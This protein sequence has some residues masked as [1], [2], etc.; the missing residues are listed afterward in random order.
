MHI[1]KDSESRIVQSTPPDWVEEIAVDF[2]AKP[3]SGKAN[4]GIWC[5]LVN[6]Q[7]NLEDKVFYRRDV[8]KILTVQGAQEG[9]RIQIRFDPQYQE[10]LVHRLAIVR[11]GRV[12]DYLPDQEVQVLQREEI[13]EWHVFSGD[14][15]AVMLLKDIQVGDL[16][17]C[18]H[19]IK[20]KELPHKM[21]D[22]GKFLLRG[23]LSIQTVS[24][25]LLYSSQ[26]QVY[27]VPHNTQMQPKMAFD[28]NGLVEC[29]WTMSNP[30]PI[31]PEDG[32][33]S[34]YD[35]CEWV[36]YGAYS[37]WSEFAAWCC[38][39]FRMPD[40]L[41][42]QALEVVGRLQQAGGTPEE[43]I[44]AALKFVQ[45]EIRYVSISINGHW[46][47]PHD[48]KT[49][50]EAGFGD[51][52][53]KSYLLCVL[54]KQLGIDAS[55]AL[56]NTYRQHQIE[57][58]MPGAGAFNHAITCVSHKGKVYWFDATRTGQRGILDK[59][60]CSNFGK[61]LVISPDTTGLTDVVPGMMGGKL[62]VSENFKVK[63]W[64]LPA[65]FTVSMVYEG[66]LAEDMRVTLENL[67]EDALKLHFSKMYA[68]LYPGIKMVRPCSWT[69]DKNSNQLKIQLEFSIN[70]LWKQIPDNKNIC[71]AFFGRAIFS[72]FLNRPTIKARKSPLAVVHPITVDYRLMVHLTKPFANARQDSTIK[73]AAFDC[74]YHRET[75]STIFRLNMTYK[76]KKN[77]VMSKEIDEYIRALDNLYYQ[78]EE[79]VI[80]STS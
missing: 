40:E 34:W 75:S 3:P 7:S 18:A 20:E 39:L 48:I 63:K 32:A 69:D 4:G 10:L 12:I 68:V 52:K 78:I 13:L 53:D 26:R 22:H 38:E 9:S 46:Q 73:C 58:G 80:I 24:H 15:T 19:S 17:D 2:D 25:R 67:T 31:L 64:N 35:P 70:D 23:F 41:P 55:C 33:P 57:F 42:V 50:L 27:V 43:K 28:K 16:I 60:C 36:E 8:K 77:H 29:V 76:S 72:P 11:D 14:L 47:K 6:S 51:C 66:T 5:M 71:Y 65:E 30:E 59:I 74:N 54:L 79:R 1:L 21:K 61:A 62:S 56:V 49:I 37:S 44:R 45:E